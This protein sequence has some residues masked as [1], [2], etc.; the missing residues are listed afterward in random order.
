M[1]VVFVCV[2]V[3]W[4]VLDPKH[5]LAMPAPQAAEVIRS[6]FNYFVIAQIML[7]SLLTPGYAAGALAEEKDRRTLEAVLATDLRNRE[8]VLSKLVVRLANLTLMLLTGEPIL[9]LLQFLGGID[10]D[11]LVAGHASSG[12]TQV[13]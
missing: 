9:G 4:W 3:C 8:I 1:L 11:L 6:F 7:V 2:F 13:H 5:T 12:L 10:P